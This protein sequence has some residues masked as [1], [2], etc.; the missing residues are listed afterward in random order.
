MEI[1]LLQD[2]FTAESGFSE[3]SGSTGNFI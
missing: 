2:I 3:K 1:H